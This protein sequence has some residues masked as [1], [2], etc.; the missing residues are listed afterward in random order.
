MTFAIFNY[1][2]FNIDGFFDKFEDVD[3]AKNS[4]EEKRR[5]REMVVTHDPSAC[6]SEYGAF[7]LMAHFPRKM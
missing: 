4:E 5:I 3:P 6:S 7:A 2:S 1:F